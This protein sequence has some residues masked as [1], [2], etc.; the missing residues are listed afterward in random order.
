MKT[1]TIL[2]LACLL[3]GASR[4]APQGPPAAEAPK[5]VFDH[6]HALLTEILSAH[7]RGDRVDYEGLRE[8]RAKLDRYLAVLERVTPDEIAS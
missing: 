1:I 3:A 5:A 6:A 2:A 8:D 7:V 4:P